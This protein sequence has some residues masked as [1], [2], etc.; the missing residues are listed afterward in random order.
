MKK[1][2]KWKPLVY[3][4]LFAVSLGSFLYFSIGRRGIPNIARGL[5]ALNPWWIAAAV[6]CVL[7]SWVME[8][9]ALLL[10]LP[11]QQGHVPFLCAV[12]ATAAGLFFGAVSPYAVAG[13]P[14]QLYVLH[15]H[16]IRPG[17]AISSLIQK[18]FLYQL[19]IAVSFPIVIL[20]YS[21][22]LE[23]LFPQFP[24]LVWPALFGQALSAEFIFLLMAKR[25][26]AEKL[27]HAGVRI[28]SWTHLVKSPESLLEKG[29]L[30]LD[31][32]LK[33][34]RALFRSLRIFW[35]AELCT[36][37]QVGSLFLI[38]L[39]IYAALG[40]PG[41]P[42]AGLTA[43]QAFVT[44]TAAC[45]PLP[46]G[47]GVAESCFFAAFS[48][49]F[50][51]SMLPQAM[52]LWRVFTYYSSLF[53]GVFLLGSGIARRA[54]G[55]APQDAQSNEEISNIPGRI[56]VSACLCG[57]NCRFDGSNKLDKELCAFAEANHALLICPESMAM[58]TPR[59]PGE[60]SGDG[61]VLSQNG[62]DL[63]QFYQDGAQ[64]TL[65]LCREN[66]VK[67]AILK[68]KSPS[69]GVHRIYDGSFTGNL[70]DGCGITAALLK[71]NGIEI[72]SEDDWKHERWIFQGRSGDSTDQDS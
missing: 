6:G 39:C 58:Q 29:E 52:F 25:T 47:G 63:T 3:A 71:Q 13:Q 57:K 54:A 50:S 20:P 40:N 26:L 32:F 8:C 35:K 33:S 55:K 43:A 59:P 42:A 46:G 69:C 19:C 44:M 16:G 17:E 56:A 2:S 51:D 15:R 62:E 41:L 21:T 48:P 65:E 12:R 70:V 67:W 4:A 23:G 53:A 11:K 30:Q 24:A 72:M 38:P 66:G 36:L 9:C 5:S 18:F 22:F 7:L 45:S 31:M 60:L 14:M 64:R 1:F 68:E 37:F 49:F 61:R 27:L 10:L 28:L 34:N